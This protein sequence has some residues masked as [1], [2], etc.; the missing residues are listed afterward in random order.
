MNY[1][2]IGNSAAAIGATEAIRK[3]DNNG[4]III[5]SDEKYHTYSRPLISYLLLGKTTE[6]RMKYRSDSFYKDNNVKLL[7]STKAVSIDKENKLVVTSSGEKIPYDKL[8]VSTGSSP[9][10]PPMEGLENVKNKFTF[11]NLDDAKALEAVIK[12]GSKV[13]IIGAGLIGLKCAEGISNL[14]DI[15][16]VDLASKPLSS[17]LDDEAGELVKAHLEE[18]GLKL[19]L[20]ESV[21]RF[22]ENT[23]ELSGGEIIEFDALVLAVGVRP[24]VS[25]IKDIGGAVGRG[26]KVDECSRTSIEDVFSAG[27]CTECMDITTG[28]EKVMALL[29]NAYM[30]GECAGF[31]MAGTD[32][33][34]DKAMPMNA[35]GFFGLHMVTAGEYKG[36]IFET[37][38]GKNLKKLFYEDNKLKGFIII[39]NVEKSGIYTAL[40]REQKPLDSIDFDLICQ[41]PGLMAFSKEDR[42]AVL[43][44]K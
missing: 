26:I 32:Y 35:I 4:E 30:Q 21:K 10:I 39:G 16:L 18:N 20:K 6:E 28:Q 33:V 44:A 19:R 42:S 34:F 11:S 1:V 17:I 41:E 5:I 38:Q 27:D 43:S 37:R 2:I 36:K 25:L 24:N 15:T 7:T 40:I 22:T 3:V 23:A 29:P 14:A 31:N 13:L 8:L 9:F 12:K